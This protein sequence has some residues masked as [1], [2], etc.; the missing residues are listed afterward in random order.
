MLFWCLAE[1]V[2]KKLLVLLTNGVGVLALVEGFGAVAALKGLHLKSAWTIALE[3]VMFSEQGG[4]LC[5]C[6]KQE[7]KWGNLENV[8]NFSSA[9]DLTI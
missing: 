2:G 6:S 3:A 7:A 1:E 8:I 9:F 4:F 5:S